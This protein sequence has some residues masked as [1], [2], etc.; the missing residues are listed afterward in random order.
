MTTGCMRSTLEPEH[1]LTTQESKHCQEALESL[2][3][4]Q[5]EIKDDKEEGLCA[6]N[7]E[8]DQLKKPRRKDT[9]VLNS[10]PHIPGVRL[11]KAE[12]QMVHLEDEEKDVKD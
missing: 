11:M 9:P 7:Q 3:D 8:E 10:P 1:R 4:R 6:E 5:S 12:K 2:E